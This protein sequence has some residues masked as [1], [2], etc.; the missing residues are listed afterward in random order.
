MDGGG[1]GR[2]TMFRKPKVL[3]FSTGDS[4]RSQM[5]EGFF[6]TLAGDDFVAVSTA[7]ESAGRNP[8]AVEG[9]KEVG[10]GIADQQGKDVAQ[11]GKQHFACVVPVCDEPKERS[12]VWPFT[13]NIFQWSLLEPA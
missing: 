6:R 1:T 10:A 11:S 3:F 4:T 2:T 12:P 7:T 8:L 13:P 5:A 9:M